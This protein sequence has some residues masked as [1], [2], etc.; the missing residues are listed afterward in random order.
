VRDQPI[1]VNLDTEQPY[2]QT[3]R[4][5]FGASEAAAV[6]GM[7]PYCTTWELYHRKIGTVLDQGDTF[8][9]RRGKH[10]EPWIV[11]EFQLATGIEVIRHPVG[12]FRAPDQRW[13]LATPD[14]DLADNSL[15]ECK[16]IGWRMADEIGEPG[17]DQLP[18]PWIL[19]AQQQMHVMGRELVRFGV[20][21]EVERLV[22][23]NIPRDDRLIDTL[24]AAEGDL[25][26]RIV[27]G[28]PPEVAEWSHHL[29]AVKRVYRNIQVG[30]AVE[31]SDHSRDSWAELQSLKLA[32]KKIEE[33]E[34]QIKAQVYAEIGDANYGLLGGD[35]VIRRS[36]VKEA[37]VKYT[38]KSYIDY[39]EIKRP[40]GLEGPAPETQLQIEGETNHGETKNS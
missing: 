18:V 40:K 6:V 9:T 24:I 4:S 37:E 1:L 27:S 39:R 15:L 28:K 33:R 10:L 8:H 23:F 22:I 2:A 21:I 38:R 30:N 11:Q 36:I 32:R 20:M 7:D 31:L 35:R 17:S 12:V 3:H 26:G 13:M 34:E 19:Q 14:A 5:G 29:E 25:W 16:S